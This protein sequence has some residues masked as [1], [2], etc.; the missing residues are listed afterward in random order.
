MATTLLERIALADPARAETIAGHDI[1]VAEVPVPFWKRFRLV[2]VMV[3]LRYRPLLLRYADDGERAI[4]IGHKEGLYTVNRE[5]G[6]ILSTTSD[7]EAYVRFWFEDGGEPLAYLAEDAG[8]LG[9]FADED[10][11]DNERKAKEAAR[12]LTHPVVVTEHPGGGF[13]VEAVAVDQRA[14]V[15]YRLHVAGD[16]TVTVN[17]RRTLVE[18]IPVPYV[19][20]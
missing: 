6:L 17:E 2:R 1:A 4:A 14:L 7:A 16:G 12:P 10:M 11:D 3:Q 20:P 19:M 8:Q 5:E 13:D 15:N 9:W 18:G